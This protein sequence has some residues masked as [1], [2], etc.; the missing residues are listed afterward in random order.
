MFA[1]VQ[2]TDESA[3]SYGYT[4]FT[5]DH[6]SLVIAALKGMTNSVPTDIPIIK[7]ISLQQDTY[8]HWNRIQF[9][10]N[11]KHY[12]FLYTGLKEFNYLQR[13]LVKLVTV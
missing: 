13:S 3:V 10:Y 11:N 8:Y 2:I 9:N 4:S 6:Q 1:Y 5:F 7:I 12:I